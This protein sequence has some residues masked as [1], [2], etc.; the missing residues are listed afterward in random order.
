[1]KPGSEE[2]F[3]E[4]AEKMVADYHVTDC[5]PLDS[6]IESA[7]RRVWNAG[8]EDQAGEIRALREALE[9]LGSMEAF[10][11]AR[12][13][14][15]DDDELIARVEFARAVLAEKKRALDYEKLLKEV[16][17]EAWRWAIAAV[18]VPAR[19]IPDH[20]ALLIIMN[21]K[22]ASQS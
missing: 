18:D 4:M 15:Y 6:Y 5:G 11:T 22:I 1:M 3:R 21:A 7:L 20:A 16:A 19:E 8:V 12:A 13:T 14:A 17:A 10:K 9:R 2:W